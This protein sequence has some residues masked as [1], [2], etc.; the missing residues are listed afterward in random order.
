MIPGDI[1]IVGYD[2][3]PDGTAGGDIICWAPAV[4]LP[5]GTTFTISDNAWLG[6]Q[7]RTG[8]GFLTW[9]NSTA[10]TLAAGTIVTLNN[11]LVSNVVE[12][13]LGSTVR[14]GTFDLS[15]GEQMVVFEG[16]NTNEANPRF[17][18]GLNYSVNEW[19]TNA[20]SD[21]VHSMLPDSLQHAY[22][23]FSFPTNQHRAVYDMARTAGNREGILLS[24]CDVTKWMT[25]EV[26]LPPSGAFSFS[27]YALAPGDVAI[28]GFASGSYSGD[29]DIICWVP[30]VDLLPG[31]TVT[32]T[33]NGWLNDGWRDTEGT[34][35]WFND[36]PETLA[37]GTMVTYSTTNLPT[38]S[39]GSSFCSTRF[40]L[41][42][43][44]QVLI[45]EGSHADPH[46]LF[47]FDY[48][49]SGWAASS[50]QVTNTF[51]SMLPQGLQGRPAVLA[52]RTNVW[53]AAYNMTQTNGNR[54]SILEAI[55]NPS[56][57]ITNSIQLPPAGSFSFW[58]Y[59]IASPLRSGRIVAGDS[60]RLS[61][62]VNGKA[63]FE[64][65]HFLWDI[66]DGR[67]SMLQTPGI[68]PFPTPGTNLIS[69]YVTNAA[70]SSSNAVDARTLIVVEP[71][72][73]MADL[74]AEEFNPP[75]NLAP[76]QP[77]IVTYTARNI[78]NAGLSGQ[79]WKD[80]A[81][82][83][84][85]GY[86]D[87]ED[88]S[89]ATAS[90]SA[91][92]GAEGTYTNT[93]AFTMPSAAQTGAWYLIVS[94]ND[95]W[96]FLENHRL[97]NEVAVP[98]DVATPQLT[99]GIA[100][101]GSLGA[102]GESHIYRIEVSA[103]QS[104]RVL[105]DDLDNRGLTEVYL[106]Q[107]GYPTRGQ[108]DYRYSAAGA[109]Q[110]ILVTA[111]AAGTWYVL[112][113]SA[114]SGGSGDYT[115]RADLHL[116]DLSS[117][118][119]SA[120]ANNIDAMLT[121]TGAGFEAGTRA[122]LVAQGG[123][124]YT[125][126][127]TQVDSFTRITA[128]FAANTMPQGT[129]TVRVA[130]PDN[131]TADLPNGF[132]M[133]SPGQAKLETHLILPAGV[134]YHSLAT[135]YVE[136]ANTGTASM[137]APLL[138][139]SAF[140]NG[141][142]GALMTLKQH[143]LVEGFRTYS[144]PEGFT[145]T[146][147]F[148]ASG[149]IPG[150]LQPGESFR[151]PVYYVGWQRPWP[152][153]WPPVTWNL[154]VLKTDDT[155]AVNWADM[156]ND[157][158][159]ATVGTE[160]WNVL[161]ANF[162]AQ[163]G[164]TWG[165]YVTMLNANA[166]YL[167]HLGQRVLDLGDLLAFEFMQADGLNPMRSLAGGVD[168]A[169]EA[170]GLPLTFSRS[171][172]QSISRRYE[173]GPF[174]RGWSH[175]WQYTLAVA[176]DDTVTVTGPGG[177]RRIFQPDSRNS[178]YFPQSGDHG[179][180]RSLGGGQYSLQELNGLISVFRSDGLLD[181][182]Q[183]LNG[184]RI[185]A[186]YS[187]G[188]LTSLTHSSGRALQ[189]A[190]NGWGRI[191]SVSDP[192]GRQT[193]Y[194]YDAGG[195]HLTQVQ[196]FDGRTTLYAYGSG[197]A[198]HAITN[199][200]GAC[201]SE[202]SFAYDAQGRL[203]RTWAGQDEAAVTFEYGDQGDVVARDALG[204]ASKFCFDHR[205][206]MAKSENALG[207]A[208][209]MEY[210]VNYNLVEVT[211]PAGRS[212]RYGYDSKG[213]LIASTDP[214]GGSTRFAFGGPWN[215]LSAVTDAKSNVTRYSY[216][217][218]ANLGA[219]TYAD[220]SAE[221]WGYYASGLPSAW[222]NRRGQAIGYTYDADGR[223]LG[224]SYPDGTNAVY[225]YD[226]RG[227]L[228]A[229]SNETGRLVYTYD[230]N[231][232]L[233]RI[234]YPFGPWLQ[235]TYNE[236]GKRATSL[237]QLGH[238][239]NYFYDSAGRL[240]SMTDE[241]TNLVV[242]YA[243]DAAGRMSR[244]TVGS[245]MYTTYKYDA[246]GQITNLV[247]ILSNGTVISR[248]VY[249]YDSRGRRISMDT[250][251]GKWD[252][253]YDDLG[254]LTR[255]VF[256]TRTNDIPDQDLTYVYDAL[257]NRI[258]TI[259]ND[260][261]NE[262]T[263]NNMNQYTRT[264]A[265]DG[266]TNTYTF[267][268]DGN[269][270]TEV[271]AGGGLP[272]TTNIYAFNKENQLVGMSNLTGVW[273]NVYD[274]RGTRVEAVAGGTSTHYVVDPIGLGNVVG[275]Y[276]AYGD[277]AARYDHDFG[278]LS[279]AAA[280]FSKS[281]YAFDAI[282]NV[283]QLVANSGV[284]ANEYKYS[285]FGTKLGED[286]TVANQFQY[287]GKYGVM[288]EGDGKEFMR[289]RRYDAGTGRFTSSDP[290]GIQG[291]L[292]LY[293]YCRNRGTQWVDPKG[294]DLFSDEDGA[295]ALQ[296]QLENSLILHGW[297]ESDGGWNPPNDLVHV[298]SDMY[299]NGVITLPNTHLIP[300]PDKLVRVPPGDDR[301][302]LTQPG[303]ML[304]PEIPILDPDILALLKETSTISINSIDPNE[305]IGPSGYGQSGHV[306]ANGSFAYRID[307]ENFTNASAPAQ[308]VVITD[309]LSTNLD[310][311]T[312]ELAELGFGDQI[313]SIPANSQYF[314]TTVPMTYSNVTFDVEIEAG[315]N[316]GNGQAYASFYS[317]DPSN[318]LPPAVDIGFLPPE[319]GTG[320][321]MGH[322]SYTLK[323]KTNLAH[324]AE[325]R[326]VAHISFDNQP[327]VKTDQV[328]PLDP[329]QGSDPTK[330]CLNTI[331]TRAPFS[332]ATAQGAVVFGTNLNV[333]WSG[334]DEGAGIASYDVYVREDGGAW[335]L[336]K[337]AETNASGTFTGL[338]CHTYGFRTVARD[339][340]GNIEVETTTPDTEAIL[341][342]N[343]PPVVAPVPDLASAVGQLVEFT[344][345]ATDAH[346]TAED[347]LF[348]LTTNSPAG[349]TIDPATG[350]VTW[351]PTCEQGRRT[352]VI[353]VVAIDDGCPYMTATQSVKVYV[354][355]CL[356]VSLGRGV[357]QAS[358]VDCLP[359][360][361]TSSDGLTSLVTTIAFPAGVFSAIQFE[362]TAAEIQLATVTSI[363]ATSAVLR[364]TPFAGQ[365]IQGPK[366]LGRICLTIAPN[367]P[368]GFA[369]VRVAGL[370]GQAN[371]GVAIGNTSGDAG[372]MVVVGE[373]PLLE[374]LP[375]S[376]GSPEL[377]LY[378]LP[379]STQRVMYSSGLLSPQAWQTWSLIPLTNLMRTTNA[380]Q[381]TGA[382]TVI[383]SFKLP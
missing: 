29:N 81:Y 331:D 229:A 241:N 356:Q 345:T 2:K 300:D 206:L 332:S 183:D 30:S 58:H 373:E 160:A 176:T 236:A 71:P 37:A 259:E 91:E 252:Y 210:D 106:R 130:R 121:L 347:L 21:T 286:K 50:N 146:I 173:I 26:V 10:G 248:F 306:A 43:G 114:S 14:I 41:N 350:V 166:A 35:I 312:F 186:G 285:P 224:K 297:W 234:D 73:T 213:N 274:A 69:L 315:V 200:S 216:T 88:I 179:I 79:A 212:H 275:E 313:I 293:G 195:E 379:G 255:A 165:S 314:E 304:L 54:D 153:G 133:T 266:K 70:A 68:I 142:P 190:Y 377:V 151:V 263:A 273:Q 7:W 218:Q 126:A 343:T 342:T 119:P 264:V 103:G 256:D 251:D 270:V 108:Y 75:G 349:A 221:R 131:A 372:R 84:S 327:A 198:I 230:A 265:S 136:Y 64:E 318:G 110:D 65:E 311:A 99:N 61:T 244:K 187:G 180:L 299:D 383:K 202:R 51:S 374:I 204:Q 181:Y 66:G 147:Q 359:Y 288:H 357:A 148:L 5:P 301:P 154:G 139:L 367:E 9:S 98:V 46:F 55:C 141:Q 235:F 219:I 168:V 348:S 376:N 16:A 228:V 100:T 150:T 223:L 209:H 260:V 333:S 232:W 182:M 227:N 335:Q 336:W 283:Q 225:E 353:G 381:S 346:T 319:D 89:L 329:A 94:V 294:E 1:V 302:S 118:T 208:V 104:L 371:G 310:W 324:G 321:G 83:S 237:D 254:Q 40:D 80:C 358:Q 207:H 328:D 261:T 365:L 355:D 36:T 364:L 193:I 281:Y 334:V 289:A 267:D 34:L 152:A 117:V 12:S 20:I 172:A 135:I 277:L 249:T 129:Y 105:L 298:P 323:A 77:A 115:L 295:G 214:L 380:P 222:T 74:A 42:V 138:V 44:E 18:F 344:N 316:L 171:F 282:G 144:Q 368:S 67:W 287:N 178:D 63:G 362:P 272:T 25:N 60:L 78:G 48:S 158:Q 163:V 247:N 157:M 238:Q 85:D 292:N 326:N 140:L 24:I 52:L 262:Y 192:V 76:G 167:G 56:L 132:R 269:L 240:E 369:W 378:G 366:Q 22:T 145:H 296:W 169:V 307:F 116:V 143:R 109:D 3:G 239:L 96:Q 8:E 322:I 93:I 233:T 72:G 243:Y 59:R 39:V 188:R 86:L 242:L 113:Y 107:G 122:L 354:T 11:T 137:P 340:V 375:T 162:T 127:V 201:C 177:S 278:L 112:V 382:V 87:V 338:P 250:L 47:A 97:N 6:N 205:G 161:W 45:Y 276:D 174:G 211:D 175:N 38:T 317:I 303:T 189:I 341:T 305:K 363:T 90:V 337:S 185:T 31:S 13:T 125:A 197:T 196:P 17:L 32:F 370:L 339:Y 27:P 95:E 245:G 170:P 191:Q 15:S 28:V 253:C 258:R 271:M 82:L 279:Q 111:P 49:G 280:L 164:N 62:I 325:I 159:P 320:R 23:A 203:A 102:L 226:A 120:H 360:F 92:V 330:Q 215:R 156:K 155:N 124:T 291:G 184:N 57:W 101:S 351:T 149:S 257:G 246:A 268:A 19:A 309:Q 231:D 361:M 123:A 199:I 284:V 53:A 217:P 33:D 194:S 134:G 4:D 308:Q 128:T 352:N 220:D 290:I